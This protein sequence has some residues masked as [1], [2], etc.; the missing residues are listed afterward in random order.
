[1]QDR[2]EKITQYLVVPLKG[3][4]RER[5]VACEYFRKE[6]DEW[7]AVSGNDLRSHKKDILC[8]TQPPYEEAVKRVPTVDPCL[9]LFAGVAKTRDTSRSMPNLMQVIDG[10][11][12]V[13]VYPNT[14]RSLILIFQRFTNDKEFGELVATTDPDVKN[15]PDAC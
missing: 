11:I 8:I 14:S 9:H 4:A 2:F 6:K 12:I 15:D 3:D 10:A 1:M 5:T 7:I 13:A